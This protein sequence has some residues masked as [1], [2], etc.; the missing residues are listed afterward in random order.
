AEPSDDARGRADD[1]GACGDVT[2]DDGAGT[3]DGVVPDRHPGE[4]GHVRP[5]PYVAAED[6]ARGVHVG[7]AGRVEVVVE[8]REDGVVPDEAAVPD[9]DAALVLE[10]AAG[11]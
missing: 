9:D 7:A 3:D 1:D 6:D 10:A 8:R 11:V 4:D 2:G 5:E